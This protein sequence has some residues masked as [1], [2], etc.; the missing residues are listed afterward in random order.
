LADIISTFSD[1]EI[2]AGTLIGEAESL[3][4]QGMAETAC[5]VL[6]RAAAN[7]HWMGGNNVR[8]VCLAPSQY[9]T[10][11]PGDNSDRER[12][13]NI[14]QNNPLYGPYVIATGIAQSAISGSL[15]DC[16]NGAVSYYDSDGCAQPRWAIGKTPCY[17]NVA[18]NYYDLTEVA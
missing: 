10:W 15:A 2:F 4:E 11:N 16:T 8:D 6:N 13:I 1:L 18:R 12:V 17:V 9:S 14:I 7:L 3:G 5:T